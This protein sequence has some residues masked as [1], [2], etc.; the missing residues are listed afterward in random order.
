MG[1]GDPRW[2]FSPWDVMVTDRTPF[3]ERYPNT[4]GE[5]QDLGYVDPEAPGAG[6]ET[7]LEHT[8]DLPWLRTLFDDRELA[9]LPIYRRSY[10]LPGQLYADL[11]RPDLGVLKAFASRRVR[12]EDLLVAKNQVPHHLWD[13][14]VQRFYCSPA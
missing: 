8:A 12:P 10:L 14:L 1:R 13:R 6:V 7:A 5:D 9:R 2:P 3:E 11:R 4:F